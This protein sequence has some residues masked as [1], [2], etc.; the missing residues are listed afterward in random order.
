MSELKQESPDP[1]AGLRI[2]RRKPAVA[3]IYDPLRAMIIS[4]AIPPG[5]PLARAALAERFGVSQQP[6]R[7]ALL[8]LEAEGLVDT[9]P[10]S[11][12]RVSRIDLQSVHEA[13]FLRISTELE[14]VRIL[15]ENAAE[16]DFFQIEM[17]IARQKRLLERGDIASF[18][19]ADR[20]MHREMLGMAGV[21]GLWDVIRNRSGHL[22]RLRNLHLPTPGKA[23]S[24]VD[25]HQ[26]I[27]DAMTAGDPDAARAAL[28][29][30]LS[31][32]IASVAE[33]REGYPGYLTD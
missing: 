18:A 1:F 30:H 16:T 7:E 20:E 13:Q 19:E 9:F 11:S 8:K 4:L 22:D 29:A 10:Q 5:A 31:G 27:Y 25:E 15:A 17:L 2:D 23:R 21:P 14:V 32:T 33:L 6:V 12:T 26:R 3:Q 24:V 28:R